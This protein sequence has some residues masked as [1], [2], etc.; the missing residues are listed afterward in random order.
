MCVLNTIQQYL[1]TE[2]YIVI[3]YISSSGLT[4]KISPKQEMTMKK[5]SKTNIIRT[6]SKTT[7]TCGG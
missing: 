1:Y 5:K 7:I 3:I 6:T 4:K 2:L